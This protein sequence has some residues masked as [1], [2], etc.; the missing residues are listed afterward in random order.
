MVK[1]DKLKMHINSK[2]Y[3]TTSKRGEQKSP[4]KLVEFNKHE[5]MKKKITS[6]TITTIE[7]TM[8]HKHA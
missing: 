5:K 8:N 7:Q 3:C 4:N 1:N 2:S 6:K